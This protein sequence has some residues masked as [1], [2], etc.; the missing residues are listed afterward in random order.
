MK[1]VFISGYS[2]D[3]I[4]SRGMLDEKIELIEKTFNPR[5]LL[6]KVREVLDRRS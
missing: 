5:N 6:K 4:T 1:T 3:F 2:A